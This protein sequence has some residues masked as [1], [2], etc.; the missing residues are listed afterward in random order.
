ML[1]HARG[2]DHWLCELAFD[3]LSLLS[4]GMIEPLSEEGVFDD[5]GGHVH[6]LQ[7]LP[8]SAVCGLGEGVEH[9][10]LVSVVGDGVLLP[11]TLLLSLQLLQLLQLLLPIW[12]YGSGRGYL[13]TV[14]LR[15]DEVPAATSVA[16]CDVRC[17]VYIDGRWYQCF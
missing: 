8:S 17:P 3:D 1:L 14:M 15:G 7:L 4:I 13:K 16:I 2:L 11:L 6:I 5:A 12:T 9:Q 10:P